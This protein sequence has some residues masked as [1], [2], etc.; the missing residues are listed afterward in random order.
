VLIVA[1]VVAGL[2]VLLVQSVQSHLVSEVDGRLIV[3]ARYVRTQ[4]GEN[5]FLPSSSPAGQY[6]QFFLAN[7]KLFGSSEN[8]RG[9]P[10]LITVRAE[11]PT[12]QL[13]T[14][15]TRRYGQLRVLEEQ[16][17][18]GSAPILVE[19]QEINQIADATH[20]LTLGVALGAPL[21]ILA[22]G[23]LIRL[24]VGRAMKSVESVRLAVAQVSDDRLDERVTNP[25]TGDELERLVLTMN[26]MLERLQ[27]AIERER[28]FVADAS[29]E[30]RS[31]IAATRAL[32][33][34]E[35]SG[36]S[37]VRA[38]REAALIA[39]QRLQDLTDQL[40]VLDGTGRHREARLKMVDVDELVLAQVD[41]LRRTTSFDIDVSAVSGGQVLGDEIDVM[42]V[43]EN[44]TSN[45][46]WHAVR[47]V[48][49]SVT[50][51]EGCVELGVED[52]GPGVPIESR[53]LIFERFLRLDRNRGRAMGG[54]G[55][56]LAIVSEIVTKYGGSV[57]VEDAEHG[58]ARFV[59]VLPSSTEPQ[60]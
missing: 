47:R 50:E 7:G 23:V 3:G 30:I 24:V 9:A 60:R 40:L 8:L 25:G 56:G 17:G 33:E 52:D 6:G 5:H 21:L 48:A 38:T 54:S 43:I 20:S 22:A 39:L 45:A 34:S 44:L 1:V 32:L 57:R 58:G 41:Q 27:G 11:G 18:M 36:P 15:T 53:S 13:S 29:H 35:D 26:V 10:P 59:V 31:P 55:L 42:R 28:Q 19:A 51:G 49:F 12:P 2:S 16:L 37:Q 46:V 4:L 14:I